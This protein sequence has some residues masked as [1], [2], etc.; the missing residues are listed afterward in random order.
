[1]IDTTLRR[2]SPFR[3]TLCLANSSSGATLGGASV[4]ALYRRAARLQRLQSELADLANG[5]PRGTRLAWSPA[6]QIDPGKKTRGSLMTTA[7]RTALAR[8]T[9]GFC[10]ALG[11]MASSHATL[12]GPN[13][14]LGTAD[15][16]FS[17]FAGFSY[18]HL[19]DFEDGLFNVPGVSAAGT[20]LCIAGTSCF[21]GLGIIDSVEN[22]QAGHD[23][24]ASGSITYTF[25]AGVLGALPNAGR[26]C[27]E[28]TG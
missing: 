6:I 10:I 11:M 25:N 7:L 27:V 26:P 1:M 5:L 13:P 24:W 14:Y 12:L 19:E 28:P 4:D 2:S 17:P 20:G 16:P 21:V 8:H 23:H 9:A 22:G 15:S 18:F 3:G